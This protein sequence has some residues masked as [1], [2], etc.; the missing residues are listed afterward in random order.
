MFRIID[1]LIITK[2]LKHFICSFTK[3][4]RR[5]LMDNSCNLQTK[6][7]Q[8]VAFSRKCKSLIISNKYS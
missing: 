8:I 4:V 1:L 2:N 7:D 6:F 5:I 3:Y